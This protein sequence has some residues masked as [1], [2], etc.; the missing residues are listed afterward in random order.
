[1]EMNKILLK[2][3]V[4]VIALASF[5]MAVAAD[6]DFV[7]NR[8]F[9]APRIGTGKFHY[10]YRTKLHLSY[11]GNAVLINAANPAPGGS[12]WWPSAPCPP[13]Y[14]GEQFA[15]VQMTGALS[16]SFTIPASGDFSLRWL[17]AGRPVSYGG[18][19]NGDEVYDVEIDGVVVSKKYST[20][21]GEP[22]TP[23][24][25]A[26]TGL[27]AGVHTLT[28]RGLVTA[29]DETAFVDNVELRSQA[30]M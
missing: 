27:S 2:C 26:L 14:K 12:E 13:G 16:Q 18:D 15:G 24:H 3:V 21:S 30:A 25:L 11:S 17:A 28:F 8:S 23:Q 1:M 19:H 4:V 5:S 7:L 29:R 10:Y 9:E 6:S 22:F 20:T